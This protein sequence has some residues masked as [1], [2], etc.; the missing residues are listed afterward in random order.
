MY[1]LEIRLTLGPVCLQLLPHSTAFYGHSPQ[2]SGFPEFFNNSHNVHKR[3]IVLCTGAF[4]NTSSNLFWFFRGRGNRVPIYCDS[5]HNVD[6]LIVVTMLNVDAWRRSSV[7]WQKLS[8][9]MQATDCS[10]FHYP[11]HI[12]IGFCSYLHFWLHFY[13]VLLVIVLGF[14]HICIGFGS[15]LNC[16]LFIFAMQFWLHLHWV[17]LIFA[18]HFAHFCNAL[19]IAFALSF[20]HISI[21]YSF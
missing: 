4:F 12:C 19:L 20:V 13:W 17:F 10:P 1:A 16:T 2:L 3:L 15:Y 18:L 5:W 14:A 7:G 6:I 8:P 21:D 11:A 9:S